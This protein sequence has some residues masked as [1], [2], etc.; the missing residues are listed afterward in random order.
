[1]PRYLTTSELAELLRIKER[2]VYDMASS[3]KIPCTRAT[4]KLLFARHEIEAWLS[5]KGSNK[6]A[7][8]RM[9]LR[10]AVFLGSHDPLLDWALKESGC[11]LATNFDGSMDGLERFAAGEGLAAAMH[12]Y[13]GEPSRWNTRTVTEKFAGQPVVLTEFCWRERGL[14]VGE[15]L[16]GRIR[17]VADLRGH[18]IAPRQA[19]AGSQML[20]LHLMER[21]QLG[22]GDVEFSELA[23][24]ETDAVNSILDG[25]ADATLGLSS[26][27]A[28]FNL[29]FAP[30]MRER[31]DLL[32]DRR[33]WFE[34]AFQTFLAFCRS[35]A[36][37]QRAE[38]LQ[39]Y[40]LSEFGKVHFNG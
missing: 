7:S 17:S 32:V 10:P 40:D 6:P 15:K 38:S 3:G 25:S 29:D 20:L 9:N 18:R 21:Q 26:V 37:T 39:G 8:G 12:L 16:K 28:R 31:F 4:G 23:Y 22:P 2:K 11:R 1:M 19:S 34:P 33:A 13:E 24:T 36:F 35:P 27:A 30:L 5:E 14:V